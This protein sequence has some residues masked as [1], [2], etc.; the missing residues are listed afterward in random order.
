MT[1]G[2][3]PVAAFEQPPLVLTFAASDPTSGAGL[4]AD[5]LTIASLGCHG[6]SVLT[7][8]TVQDSAGVDEVMALDADWVDDQA[9]TLLEDMSVSAFKLGVLCSAENVRVIAEIMSDYPDIPLVFDPVLASGRGDSLSDEEVI[10]AIREL[11][12]PQA[13]IVTPN[14]LEARRLAAT[15]QDEELESLTLD[16]CAQRLLQI[17][18]EYVL[19]TGTH[20]VSTSVTNR[21]FNAAGLV[22]ADEWQRLPGS[23]HGS[24]CTL[25]SAIA[26]MLALGADLPDAVQQAQEYTWN[27][28]AHAFRP[29][30]GQAIPDRFFWSRQMAPND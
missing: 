27:T 11:L 19:I 13:T 22:R 10:E 23:Y 16:V 3:L 15:D 18:A 17:G 14:S 2:S 20:E 30:M 26:A 5:L 21:L 1:S 28:L 12:L 9:R 4:Q 29:G 6:T 24:G 8:I 7:G 25:A